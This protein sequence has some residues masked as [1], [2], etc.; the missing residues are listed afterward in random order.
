MRIL[1]II[2]S[3]AL[4]GLTPAAALWA[5]ATP[6]LLPYSQLVLDLNDA[7]PSARFTFEALAD[8]HWSFS[9]T[10]LDGDLDPVLYLMDEG[11]SLLAA[12]DNQ[13]RD[14]LD[15]R[16]EDWIAPADGVY[17]LEIRR[18]NDD[19]LPTA[20][21]ARLTVLGDAYSL[22]LS[23][24][25][26]PAQIRL[27]AGET[28]DLIPQLLPDQA[29]VRVIFHLEDDLDNGAAV[30]FDLSSGFGEGSLG[31][32]LLLEAE[33]VVFA[34][35]AMQEGVAVDQSVTEAAA[36]LRAGGY[37]LLLE[38][39][40]AS[41]LRE[42]QPIAVF[43]GVILPRGG[44]ALRAVAPPENT[45][46][47]TLVRTY[48]STP[49]YGAFAD[50][51]DALPPLP[52]HERLFRDSDPPAAAVGE[53]RELGYVRGNGALIFTI[54]DAIIET[55][56]LG[57]SNFPLQMA[58]GYQDF[59]LYFEAVVR[60]GGSSTACGMTFR[61]RDAATFATALVSADGNV[62]ILPYAAGELAQNHLAAGSVWVDR[63]LGTR[64]RV[65]L[66]AQG[67]ETLM[68]VNGALVGGTPIEAH[69]G[70]VLFTAVVN[71]PVTSRCTFTNIWLWGLD[72]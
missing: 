35:T 6:R 42:R 18:A 4:W 50:P 45:Q 3:S 34:Q 30:A 65:L 14:S 39:G 20:G 71:E 12:N 44:L 7:S 60:L 63:G 55:S 22:P 49:F 54:P 48:A 57:F 56:T 2:F 5:Q 59:V 58:R 72:Q 40:R 32:R 27:A 37:T 25:P 43:E 41:L 62:Y 68:F 53:L 66:V 29:P 16:L 69:V 61:Q 26:I 11:G 1:L 24:L 17:T 36:A 21:R 9:V 10:V 70:E 28:Y 67:E 47:I 15:A 13:T 31:W 38:A 46:P 51:A 33:R 64:N 19:R 23:P 52:S 8:S